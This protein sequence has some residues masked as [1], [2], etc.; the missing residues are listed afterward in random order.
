MRNF[1]DEDE[2][3]RDQFVISP[4]AARNLIPP[5]EENEN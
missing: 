1:A 2:H 5:Q 4:Q 3:W